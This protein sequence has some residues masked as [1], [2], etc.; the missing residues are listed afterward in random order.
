MCFQHNIYLLEQIEVVDAELN[1]GAE[2]DTTYRVAW[3]SAV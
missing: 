3:R 2:L 1:A